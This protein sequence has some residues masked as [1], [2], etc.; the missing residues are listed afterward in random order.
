MERSRAVPRAEDQDQRSKVLSS[1]LKTE[2]VWCR[3][4]PGI[5]KDQ[6]LSKVDKRNQFTDLKT[7]VI[8]KQDEPQGTQAQKHHNK[9]DEN[10]E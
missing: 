5:N 9:M 3:E 7:L 4:D 1:G 2:R 8:P 10:Q 6:N